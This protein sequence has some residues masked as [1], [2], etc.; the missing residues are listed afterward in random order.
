M[1][2]DAGYLEFLKDAFAEFGEVTIRKMFGGAGVYRDGV[3]FGLVAQSTL[4][5]RSDATT[6]PD[7][8]AEDMGPFVYDARGKENAMP[9]HEV[10][11]RLLED[12]EALAEWSQ[13]AFAIALAAKKKR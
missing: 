13:K 9:Y 5:L 12:G 3:M 10:P 4:Y 1:A 7:F 2:V 11:E 6:A 8:E